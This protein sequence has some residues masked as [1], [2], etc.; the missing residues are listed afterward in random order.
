ME[1]CLQLDQKLRDHQDRGSH[2]P[3]QLRWKKLC[4]VGFFI[5][6]CIK[7]KA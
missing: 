2:K 7:I 3:L 4:S 6:Y 1:I 5:E